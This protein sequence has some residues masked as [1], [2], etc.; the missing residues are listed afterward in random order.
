MYPSLPVSHCAYAFTQTKQNNAAVCIDKCVL[1]A[2]KAP[3]PVCKITSGVAKCSAS[4]RLS[5]K[6]A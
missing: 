5:R 3:T 2:C 6:L 1:K 4:R